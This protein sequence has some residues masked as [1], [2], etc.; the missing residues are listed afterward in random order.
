MFQNILNLNLFSKKKKKI[1]CG[2]GVDPP[3]PVYGPVRRKVK[4][5]NLSWEEKVGT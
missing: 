5:L 3:P 1:G 4:L 2:L